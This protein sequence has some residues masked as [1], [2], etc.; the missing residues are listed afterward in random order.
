MATTFFVRGNEAVLQRLMSMKTGSSSGSI[1][2][3]ASSGRTSALTA[4]GLAT[5]RTIE[6]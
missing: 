1:V 3:I 4:R 5:T 2:W 6:R